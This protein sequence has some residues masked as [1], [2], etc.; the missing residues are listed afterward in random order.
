[1]LDGHNPFAITYPDIYGPGSGLYP[2]GVVVDGQVQSGY[3]YPPLTLLLDLPGSLAGD[4]RFALL[5]AILG[6][7]VMLGYGWKQYGLALWLLFTPKMLFILENA[8][9][10]VYAVLLLT[11][12]VWAA[13]ERRIWTMSIAAGL[14]FVSKQ[15]I[16]L[17]LPAAVLLAPA[18]WRW[19]TISRMALCAV[20]AGSA[21][22]LPFI[23]INAPAFFRSMTVVHSNIIRSD[24]ISFLP[25]ISHIFGLRLTLLC[26]VLAAAV[27][28][29]I[30]LYRA[31]RSASGFA[32]ATAFI[33]LCMFLFSPLAFINYY[34]FAIAAL[35]AAVAT[36]N[37]VESAK[38][39]AA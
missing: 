29:L 11:L 33:G 2:P 38:T 5:A 34:F 10:D 14:L 21:V 13:K 30:T 32:A 39:A 6:A 9:N 37:S 18:P 35:L 8:W 23:A 3:W 36:A 4:V 24:S 7:A 17:I 19:K 31:E 1:L 20:L 15:Y 27:A 26:P 25:M 28:S 12:V 22:T 16:V